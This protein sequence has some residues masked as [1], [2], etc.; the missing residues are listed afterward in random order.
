MVRACGYGREEAQAREGFCSARK[1]CFLFNQSKEVKGPILWFASYRDRWRKPIWT[2][3]KFSL[4][5]R[6]AAQSNGC[7]LKAQGNV[8][9]MGEVGRLGATALNPLQ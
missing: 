2:S 8:L 4:Y 5:Q 3:P 6:R 7:R 1:L 9:R